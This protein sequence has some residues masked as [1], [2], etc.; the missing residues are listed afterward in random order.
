MADPKEPAKREGNFAKP[1]EKSL[2]RLWPN[3]EHESNWLKNLACTVGLHRWHDV[4]LDSGTVA[5][6]C[7]WCSTVKV[8]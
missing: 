3:R 7:R 2:E 6:Y 4:K 1:S 5:R 8:K